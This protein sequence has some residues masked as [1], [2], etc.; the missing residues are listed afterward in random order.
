MNSILFY[1]R[2]V[3]GLCE[4]P[5]LRG[6]EPKTPTRQHYWQSTPPPCHI[7]MDTG[8]SCEQDSQRCTLL[9]D[10]LHTF[11]SLL[12]ATVASIQHFFAH[13]WRSNCEQIMIKSS[14]FCIGKT[15]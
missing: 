3:V 1:N 7:S 15:L 10:I 12:F 9:N 13:R 4:G 2:F 8:D 14:I 5:S 11:P 6:V